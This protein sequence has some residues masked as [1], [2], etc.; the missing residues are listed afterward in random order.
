MAAI[1]RGEDEKWT[2]LPPTDA[3]PSPYGPLQPPLLFA[4]MDPE[5]SPAA[6]PTGPAPLPELE[7]FPVDPEDER[8]NEVLADYRKVLLQ[9]KET[10]AKVKNSA[11][12]ALATRGVSRTAQT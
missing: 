3:P 6:S 5:P 11:R 2:R 9:H 8:R 1:E 12:R 10:E 4:K 7:P